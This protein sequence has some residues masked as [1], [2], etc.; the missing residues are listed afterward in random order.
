MKME[1]QEVKKY[2]LVG[3]NFINLGATAMAYTAVSEIKKKYPKAEVYM[4]S[5]FDFM[6]PHSNLNFSIIGLNENAWNLFIG[7]NKVKATLK[8]FAKVILK[9]HNDFSEVQKMK[10][11][12]KNCDGV[13]DISGYSLSSQWGTENTNKHLNIV[14][15]VKKYGVP[16]Y[17]MPQSFGPFDYGDDTPAVTVRLKEILPYAKAIFARENEGYDFLQNLIGEDNLYR[18]CDLVLQTRSIDE[19]SVFKTRVEHKQY[20]LHTQDNVAV[21]PNMRNFDHGNKKQIMDV[22]QQ[23]IDTLLAKGKNIYLISHSMEDQD[24]CLMIKQ[25]YSSDDRVKHIRE[26][27][28]VF[29]FEYLIKQ[30]DFVIASRFHSIVHSYKN[31]IPCLALGWAT[32][33][34][35]LLGMMEQGQYVVDVRNIPDM[36]DIK[37]K[38]NA[39]CDNFSLERVKINE[40]LE[41]IRNNN[42]FDKL[43]F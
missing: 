18:S 13:F 12:L 6:N 35:E 11:L 37:Q 23:M 24:V 38:L 29:L 10:N 27:M 1:E 15:V 32:K 2:I 41:Q 26:K 33:Y 14:Q 42:C 4:L 43:N 19:K 31:G 9:H 34:H 25:L 16:Y 30:F 5:N 3:A 36:S 7:Q 17:F 8:A 20:N 39:M 22:Y 21:I 28:D 40:K